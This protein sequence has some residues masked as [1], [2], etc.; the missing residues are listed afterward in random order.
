MA[1]NIEKF[2]FNPFQENTYIVYDDSGECIVIDA[3][4]SDEKEQEIFSNFI[5]TKNLKP[6]KLLNTH[7]HVD[8]LMGNDF[9]FKEFG[10]RTHAHKDE[11]YNL[12]NAPDHGTLFGVI[13]K[14]PSNGFIELKEGDKVQFGRS[15]LYTL[16]LPGHSAGSLA[17]YNKTQ[18]F[19][20]VGDVLF[21]DSI[22]RTDLPGGSYETLMYSIKEKLFLLG[23]DYV[24]YPGHGPSTK[25][26]KEKGSNPFLI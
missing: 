21:N 23:D 20:F 9:V 10:L 6:V 4:C 13:L 5:Q 24:I 17:F 2:V 1:I 14:L 19:A 16:H 3:G 26:A 18:K 12:E 8:H 11:R 25:I 15:F 22:G 7:C